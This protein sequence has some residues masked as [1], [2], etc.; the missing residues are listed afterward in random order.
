MRAS[1]PFEVKL[2]PQPAAPGIEAANL[3]RMTLDKRFSGDL[4]AA[5][6]GEMLSAGGNVQGSAGY[7]AIE[8]VTGTLHGKHGSFVLQHTGTMDR[9]APS[10]SIH[11]VPDSGT[12]ELTGLS[13]SMQIQIEQGKHFYTFD[14]SLP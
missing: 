3:G 12:D 9:G 6:L 14:Y 4:E 7:V 1:G 5:S 8:R 11:V 2:A 13:G 10:L